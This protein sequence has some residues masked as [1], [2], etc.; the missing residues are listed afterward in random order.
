MT[1]ESLAIRIPIGREADLDPRTAIDLERALEMLSSIAIDLA[2]PAFDWR[3]HTVEYGF[4]EGPD[5]D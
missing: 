4:L 2:V 5:D 1:T 3:Q